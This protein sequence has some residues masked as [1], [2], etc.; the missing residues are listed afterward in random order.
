MI[1]FATKINLFYYRKI[2][3]ILLLHQN[4]Y[5]WAVIDIFHHLFFLSI[6][7]INKWLII[8]HLQYY[9]TF[10]II[11]NK[12]ISPKDSLKYTKNHYLLILAWS[13][14]YYLNIFKFIFWGYALIHKPRMFLV[15]FVIF[16]T[17]F[18]FFTNFLN[19]CS[20]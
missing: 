20:M 15:N 8:F 9:L 7:H 16:L 4:F 13:K 6:F 2:I 10:L 1:R 14:I 19:S 17:L 18:L 5:S 12:Q 11:K 3:L